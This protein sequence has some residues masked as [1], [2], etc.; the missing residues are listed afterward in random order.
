M[1]ARGCAGFRS[2]ARKGRREFLRA[3]S[4][5]LS[6]MTLPALLQSQALA[7]GAA[8]ATGGRTFGRAKRCLLLF[9]WG[10][11]AQ[12]D[13]WDMKPDAAVEYRGEFKPI[14]TNVPGI[15]I[16]EHFPRLARHCD[17]LAIVRSVRHPDVC[18]ISASHYLLT[19]QAPN[20]QASAAEDWPHIGSVLGRLGRG[21][22][23]L[24]PCVSMRP[25]TPTDV[26]RFVEST[27][28]QGSG[29]LGPA[30]Q[31]FI[32]DTDPNSPEYARAE[33]SLSA[34]L[35][36]SRFERRMG[37]RERID[38]QFRDLEREVSLRAHDTSYHRAYNLLTTA[39]AASAFDLSQEP[40]SVRDRYGRH[41]HGQA[42]LQARRLL[43]AGVP[44][45]TVFWQNDGIKNVSVYW[46]THG[47]NFIDLKDRLMPPADQAFSALLEDLEQRGMLDDTVILWTGEFGRTPRVGQGV[48]GGAGATR[49]GRD[50]WPHVFTSVL[51]GGGIRGGQVYGKS[52]AVAAYPE[53]D[54]VAPADVIA[55]LYHCLGVPPQTELY[56]PLGRP[57]AI[58]SG[59]PITPIL[60]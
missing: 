16:C 42:V 6:G 8:P 35:T 2:E 39:G 38:G 32:I 33:F 51:A 17:K 58:C 23:G 10:G 48:E 4:L 52:D 47:R 9:M 54:P 21:G 49:D 27:R 5:A 45:V 1:A 7:A 41:M 36:P 55:T 25:K 29:W 34:A 12:M 60:A 44:L 31:P 46:D 11:P 28:G 30:F 59:S 19:G 20:R 26:P 3:G 53:E 50:H 24:P 13:T 43:E 37:L 57:L 40:D 14:S 18:H 15:Q 22:R 56:D